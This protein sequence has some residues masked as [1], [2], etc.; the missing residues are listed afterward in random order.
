M[1]STMDRSLVIDALQSAIRSRRP[2]L[3]MLSY[4]DRGSQYASDD[5]RLML[6]AN[7]IQQSMS[8]KGECW[9][10]AVVERF[11]GTMK[12]ELGDPAQQS[13]SILVQAG[14]S[15]ARYLAI[16]HRVVRIRIQ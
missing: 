8:G 5:F 16:C 2:A 15:C 3:G 4:S 10:N 11:F 7:G 9:D 12:S 14:L 13:R 6:E 1:K